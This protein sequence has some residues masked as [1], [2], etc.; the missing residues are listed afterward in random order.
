MSDS[1]D[2]IIDVCPRHQETAEG[3]EGCPYCRADIQRKIAEELTVALE[4][5]NADVKELSSKLEPRSMLVREIVAWFDVIEGRY[6]N[7]VTD[8]PVDWLRRARESL[9]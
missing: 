9:K 5:R 4:Q 8:W 1:C 6:D 2:Y 3:T 7:I